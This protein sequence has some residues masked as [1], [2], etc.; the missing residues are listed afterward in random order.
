M[1]A[2]GAR[3][4]RVEFQ[5]VARSGSSGKLHEWFLTRVGDQG[6]APQGLEYANFERDFKND[7][8]LMLA[9]NKAQFRVRDGFGPLSGCAA[10]WLRD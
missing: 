10:T 7:V 9:E 6:T 4:E 3:P 8:A 1:N 2:L 5:I